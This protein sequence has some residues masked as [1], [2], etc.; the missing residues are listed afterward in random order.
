MTTK[1]Y[2]NFFYIIKIQQEKIF[3]SHFLAASCLTFAYA[4]LGVVCT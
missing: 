3:F 1:I 4:N 2:E